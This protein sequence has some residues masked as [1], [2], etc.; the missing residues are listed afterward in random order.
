MTR[1][2]SS[3]VALGVGGALHAA[4]LAA[5]GRLGGGER[6]PELVACVVGW[7]LA[8]AAVCLRVRPDGGPADAGATAIGL[9]LL[10]VVGAALLLPGS[11]AGLALVVCGL[12][13]VVCGLALRL[14][15]IATLGPSFSDGIAPVG[16]AVRAGPYA[17]VNHPADLGTAL[18]AA[19]IAVVAGSPAA[20][21]AAV[22]LAAL[23]A[24]RTRAEDQVLHR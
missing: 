21:L 13:L 5:A 15:A 11:D 20:G 7:G 6:A 3:L 4:A 9:A 2:G 22:G 10:A 18:A 17:L 24:R 16:P 1:P 23:L 14:W 12:A 8:E 19:G